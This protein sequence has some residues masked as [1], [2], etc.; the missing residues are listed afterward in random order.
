MWPRLDAG[1]VPGGRRILGGFVAFLRRPDAEKA[2]KDL[3]GAEW[4]GSVLRTSWGKAVPLPV[5]PIYGTP[6][7][8]FIELL[9]FANKVFNPPSQRSRGRA[10]AATAIVT[11]PA[12]VETLAHV[13]VHGL[14]SQRT[15]SESDVDL[16]TLRPRHRET[17]HRNGIGRR[18]KPERTKGS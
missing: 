6:F 14:E 18:W 4:G 5:R 17:V 1:P 3:D 9:C 2:A 11:V 12:V 13:P 7:A 16:L 15:T 10:V 8:S